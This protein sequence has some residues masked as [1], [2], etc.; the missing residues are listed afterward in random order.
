MIKK[1]HPPHPDIDG[2]MWK[3]IDGIIEAG[4]GKPGALITVLR[5]CQE[6]VRYLPRELLSYVAVGLDL[7]VSQIFG[8]ATFLFFFFPDSQG[9]AHHQGVHRYGLLCQGNQGEPQSHPWQV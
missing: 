6:V 7:P 9:A 3:K 1:I 2:D 8:V 4:Q 5:E